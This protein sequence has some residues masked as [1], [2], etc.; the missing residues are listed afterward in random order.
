MMELQALQFLHILVVIH[1]IQLSSNQGMLASAN[2]EGLVIW[3]FGTTVRN[4]ITS[5]ETN[6][7]YLSLFVIAFYGVI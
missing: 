5:P 2:S 7:R 6:L 4:K 1:K 3:S